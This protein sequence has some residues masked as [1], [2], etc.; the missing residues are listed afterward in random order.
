MDED[1]IELVRTRA[2]PTCGLPATEAKPF[3]ARP[4]ASIPGDGFKHVAVPRACR[5]GADCHHEEVFLDSR[6]LAC[7]Y[8]TLGADH[9]RHHLDVGVVERLLKEKREPVDFPL[10]HGHDHHR[11]VWIEQAPSELEP[12]VHHGEPFG[13]TIGV[14]FIHVVVVVLPVA[15]AGVVRWIDVDRVDAAFVG[16]EKD[17]QRVEVLG[18]DDGVEG[19]T[20]A[21]AFHLPRRNEARIDRVTE[22]GDDHKVLD[23][24]L[25]R[26]GRALALLVPEEMGHSTVGGCGDAVNAPYA[27]VD[28]TRLLTASG[29]EANLVASTHRPIGK[30]YRLGDMVF[31]VETESAAPRERF[32]LASE[33]CAEVRVHRLDMG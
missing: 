7:T 20:A 11:P 17:L 31:E 23:G 4:R 18:V 15:R 6:E 22:L 28:A 29:Q 12:P 33:V 21:C 24:A 14:L 27:V 13:V 30:F 9:A 1:R 25:G 2:S 5:G 19:F 8:D 32:E 16:V 3:E 10:V 26:L